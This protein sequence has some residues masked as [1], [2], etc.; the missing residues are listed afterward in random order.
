MVNKECFCTHMDILL[1]NRASSYILASKSLASRS[2]WTSSS[3]TPASFRRPS[4]ALFGFLECAKHRPASLLAAYI[5]PPAVVP[6]S[7]V[8]PR[9]PSHTSPSYNLLPI[10]YILYTMPS[11]SKFAA[12][13]AICAFAVSVSAIP[14]GPNTLASVPIVGKAPIPRGS[15]LDALS[16][17]PK[18]PVPRAASLLS[19]LPVK[20]A[21]G[22]RPAVIDTVDNTAV[23][24]TLTE[25]QHNHIEG[26]PAVQTREEAPHHPSDRVDIP[27]TTTTKGEKLRLVDLEMRDEMKTPS[28]VPA[29][30]AR[31]EF[32]VPAGAVG[33][34][35]A[36]FATL[37]AR[38][39]GMASPPQDKIS[40]DLPTSDKTALSAANLQTRRDGVALQGHFDSDRQ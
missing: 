11:S 4:P 28:L 39:D 29:L 13:A 6:V 37:G 16:A 31:D 25:E 40:I 14:V 19:H 1:P 38:A 33:G 34:S 36:R 21:S 20:L 8:Q 23:P 15:P 3:S 2:S 5:R 26:L 35:N 12:I 27:L 32:D 18:P 30:P 22:D 10:P 7:S 9:C 24:K 17:L